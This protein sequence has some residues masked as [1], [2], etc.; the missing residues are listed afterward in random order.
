MLTSRGW[1]F[2]FMVLGTCVLGAALS[3]RVGDAIGVVGLVLLVWFLWEWAAFAFQVHLVLPRLRMTR[4][5]FDE[6]KAVPI[7]WAN[8]EFDVVVRFDLPGRFSLPLVILT[9]WAPTTAK[10]RD[11]NDEVGG[12]LRPGQ[13]LRLGYRIECPNP[14]EVRFEGVRARIADRQ[15]FF[16]HRR[17]FREQSAMLVL[18]RLTGAE[19]KGHGH[20]RQNIFPP[21]GI[22]RL[23]RPGGGSELLDLRD[24]LPGDP[25]KM[26]AWKPSARKDKL[27]TKEFESEV[28]VRCTMFVDASE[29]TRLLQKRPMI[30]HLANLAAGISEATV[31]NRDHIG[32]VVFDENESDVMRPK[33]TRRHVI[34][35]LHRLARAAARPMALG[36]FADAKL[37][38]KLAHPLAAELYPELMDRKLNTTPFRF[39]WAPSL[40]YKRGWLVL[41]F[42]MPLLILIVNY[43]GRQIALIERWPEVFQASFDFSR[44]L[45][46]NFGA[47]TIEVGT[48]I[49]ILDAWFIALISAGIALLIWVINGL[50][51]LINPYRTERMR[52]KQLGMLFATLDH[53]VAGAETHY[54]HDDQFFARRTMRFLADHRYRYPLRLYDA[55]G[56][57][58]FR[59]ADKIG[60]LVKALNYAVARGRDNELFVLMVDLIDLVQE[61][62]PL[63]RTIRVAVA[64]H[65]QVIV[66]LPWHGDVPAP[67]RD[68][69]KDDDALPMERAPRFADGGLKAVTDDLIQDMVDT[70]HRH[71][72]RLRREL[73]RLGVPVVRAETD[74]PVQVVVSRMDRLRGIG[75]RR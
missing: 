1:W 68:A 16:Y 31:A 36:P 42:L 7:L 66:V 43:M 63:I 29:S 55:R 46:R 67:P 44:F 45:Y 12:A 27:F 5:V 4:E 34:D 26:I 61:V 48:K 3:P 24:Y 10:L 15:G 30:A 11:G 33:R 65:H 41:A 70:Y 8:G 23:R 62:E 64:R 9:D 49:V 14:G 25:P 69:P 71:F 72:F 54:L 20:K 59:S 28:P 38:G 37:L 6:R 22:H 2:L 47:T 60:V 40:D 74:D 53:D 19:G 17:F 35:M 52:R 58:L 73:G 39:F 21:P 13:P 57:Y 51:G 18:P 56:R 50:S 75:G 32:L